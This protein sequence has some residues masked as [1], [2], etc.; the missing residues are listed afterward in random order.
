MLI[1]CTF[2]TLF[3]FSIQIKAPNVCALH[4]T[5]VSF[6]LNTYYIVIDFICLFDLIFSPIGLSV[7]SLLFFLHLLLSCTLTSSLSVALSQVCFASLFLPLLATLF[8]FLVSFVLSLFLSLCIFT[9]SDCIPVLILCDGCVSGS[10]S[11]A[12]LCCPFPYCSA[13]I[14]QHEREMIQPWIIQN[15]CWGLADC[16]DPYRL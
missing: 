3:L 2:L 8:P 12:L 10:F 5:L 6:L 16:S 1:S 14:L 4:V 11:C 13:A 7:S 9:S 15:G